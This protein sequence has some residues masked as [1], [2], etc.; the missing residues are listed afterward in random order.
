MLRMLRGKV[1]NP[2]IVVGLDFFRCCAR[3][4]F[5]LCYPI[6]QPVWCKA[7][8]VAFVYVNQSFRQKWTFVLTKFFF[9]RTAYEPFAHLTKICAVKHNQRSQ[10]MDVVVPVH[11]RNCSNKSPAPSYYTEKMFSLNSNKNC[12]R[13]CLSSERSYRR[14]SFNSSLHSID[15][16]DT[17]DLQRSRKRE[18]STCNAYPEK[19][20]SDPLLHCAFINKGFDV[21]LN[22]RQLPRYD[23]YSDDCRQANVFPI[24]KVRISDECGNRINSSFDSQPDWDVDDWWSFGTAKI[25][26]NCQSGDAFSIVYDEE[27]VKHTVKK[28]GKCGHKKPLETQFSTTFS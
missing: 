7:F 18:L 23:T 6:F 10:S 20:L 16:T 11:N 13:N 26:N 21:E 5:F 12:E 27:V 28:C 17:L 2:G 4:V 25:D 24:P 14:R 8:Y 3:N 1:R 22:R 19:R 9:Y 15:E